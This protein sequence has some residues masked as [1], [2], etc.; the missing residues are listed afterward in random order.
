MNTR[1]EGQRALIVGASSGMGRATAKALALAGAKVVAAARNEAALQSLCA[2]LN[3]EG[4][5]ASYVTV[6]VQDRDQVAALFDQAVS[7][8]GG[9][10]LV[11]FAAGTNTPKRAVEELSTDDWHALLETNLTGAFHTLQESVSIMLPKG[12]GTIIFIS[13]VSAK[14]GDKSGIA[15][16][17]SK[18]GMDGLVWGAHEELKGTNLRFSVIYPGLCDTPLVDKRPVPP[19]AEDREKA[20]RPEDIADA[21]LYI[22]SS[23]PHVNIKEIVIDTTHPF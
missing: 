3:A 9:L 12:S 22:A 19:S 7:T 16:Q 15:Y 20:L 6:D 14:R 2:E 1:I 8:L 23:P 4:A 18:H 5:D 13:S 10:D 17:A 11:V 21:C